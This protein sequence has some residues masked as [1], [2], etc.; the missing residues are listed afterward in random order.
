MINKG[1]QWL[2]RGRGREK[3]A[4]GKGG[5]NQRK[6]VLP[7]LSVYVSQRRSG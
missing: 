4:K 5:R 3:G 7:H 1:T 2:E 6:S